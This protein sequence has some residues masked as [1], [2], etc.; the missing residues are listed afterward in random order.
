MQTVI[1]KPPLEQLALDTVIVKS[2]Q[3]IVSIQGWTTTAL[4]N[5]IVEEMIGGKER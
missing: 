3:D 1:I 2:K 5:R 4:E